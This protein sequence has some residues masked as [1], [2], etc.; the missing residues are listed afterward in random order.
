MCEDTIYFYPYALTS[1]GAMY[2]ITYYIETGFLENHPR[3]ELQPVVL[4]R[5][6]NNQQFSYKMDRNIINIVFKTCPETSNI[7]TRGNGFRLLTYA[8]GESTAKNLK[9]GAPEIFNMSVY[10]YCKIMTITCTI[11]YLTEFAK[12]DVCYIY[13]FYMFC[14]CADVYWF[15]CWKIDFLIHCIFYIE[16]RNDDVSITL[17]LN[18][19]L[20][21]FTYCFHKAKLGP[22]VQNYRCR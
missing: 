3:D 10:C 14:T 21:F 1:A 16:S 19:L 18:A 5:S 8:S 13:I 11:L 20:T 2:P 22:V 7:K 17:E 12:C 15:L 4:T 6:S 9:C